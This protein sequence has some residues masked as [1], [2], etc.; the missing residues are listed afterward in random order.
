MEKNQKQ[1]IQKIYIGEDI[2]QTLKSVNVV[3]NTLRYKIIHQLKHM[4]A[5]SGVEITNDEKYIK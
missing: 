1:N 2:F 5:V 4:D 3:L